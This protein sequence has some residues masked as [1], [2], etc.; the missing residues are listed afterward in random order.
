MVSDA[1]GR[2]RVR[3]GL[4][5][6]ALAVSM[7]STSLAV[8]LPELARQVDATPHELQW[9]VN[10][11]TVTLAAL[12]IACGTWADRAGPR[13]PLVV[14]GACLASGSTWGA[15]ATGTE[16][17]VAA[18]VVMGLGAA[19]L[20]PLSSS[21]VARVFTGTE[22][23]RALAVWAGVVTLGAPLGLL[24]GGV[25][26]HVAGWPVI[27][28]ANVPL[29][30]A[31]SVM[32]ARRL[33]VWQPT[34]AP[35][36]NGLRMATRAVGLVLV[37]GGLAQSAVAD[38]LDDVPL[39]AAVAGLLCVAMASLGG[40]VRNGAT[41]PAGP[42]G[43]AARRSYWCATCVAAV[44]S[45]TV[46]ITFFLVPLLSSAL[47]GADCA[48]IALV[49]LP[50]L[51]AGLAGNAVTNRLRRRL[52]DSVVA[53]SGLGLVALC[54][55]AAALHP[56]SPSTSWSAA[57]VA[58]QGFGISLVL[59]TAVD[60]AL[61]CSATS[62]VP[63]RWAAVTQTWR[64]VGGAVGVASCAAAITLCSP[65]AGPRSGLGASRSLVDATQ[66][67]ATAMALA[68]LATA[69]YAVR[70]LSFPM[71]DRQETPP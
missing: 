56:E 14:G 67:L 63:A 50:G 38:S 28:W 12:I 64:Q 2:W 71:I 69:V 35:V 23:S 37:V 15:L 44:A 39:A 3:V 45:L 31:G 8:A 10:A 52:G 49:L 59:L 6:C 11:Y 66:G 21:T 55:G 7:G 30:I 62:L 33:P 29:V 48:D 5:A 70:A 17:L 24:V 41:W 58:A 34:D 43:L 61:G 16:S 1:V 46:A 4:C 57:W 51:A 68:S 9:I 32:T 25:A 18:R 42:T 36:G 47:H 20:V 19:A 60:V 27:F 13:V 65:P 26:L 22:R 40:R 53:A 54:F